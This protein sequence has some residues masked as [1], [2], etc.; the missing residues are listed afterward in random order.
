MFT[1]FYWNGIYIKFYDLCHHTNLFRFFSRFM[2]AQEQHHHPKFTHDTN[3][4]CWCPS[5]ARSS[6]F[7]IP[8]ARGIGA[9][10]QW[11]GKLAISL[12]PVGSGTLYRRPVSHNIQDENIPI[13]RTLISMY[14]PR[15]TIFLN[16]SSI[17]ACNCFHLRPLMVCIRSF[18]N[19]YFCKYQTA[20]KSSS[21][22]LGEFL[23]WIIWHPVCPP[24]LTAS[25]SLENQQRKI[26]MASSYD[27]QK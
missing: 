20:V 26:Q 1:I 2:T 24:C 7:S 14:L 16:I 12:F 11:D 19:T 25:G 21:T 4:P 22:N 15:T 18:F 5:R 9:A 17:I 13:K 6:S 3:V 10:I 23:I 27:W 8:E